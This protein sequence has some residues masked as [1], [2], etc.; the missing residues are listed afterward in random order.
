MKTANGLLR[1]SGCGLSK[2]IKSRRNTWLR[3]M[4]NKT[5]GASFAV[6]SEHLRTGLQKPSAR[7][8]STRSEEHCKR[9]SFSA[10]KNTID[11]FAFV[12]KSS[13]I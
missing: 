11:A 12:N 3:L 2:K 13:Q 9:L 1:L 5:L 8:H 10:V 4:S 6:R 7:S